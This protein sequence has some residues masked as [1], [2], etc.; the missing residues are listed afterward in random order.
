[1]EP[2]LVESAHRISPVAAGHHRDM[3]DMRIGAHR[4]HGGFDV[5]RLELGIG[6]S[7][8]HRAEPFGIVGH[9]ARPLRRSAFTLRST[10][11]QIMAAISGPPNCDTC[12]MPVGEVTLI[13]VR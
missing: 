12:R 11:S 7:V 1:D 8:D 2:G 4:G 3:V 13:S 5:A 6:M 10:T 9:R